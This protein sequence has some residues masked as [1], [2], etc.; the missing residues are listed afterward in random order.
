MTT[1]II[2]FGLDFHG[3]CS[4]V[5]VNDFVNCDAVGCGSHGPD[6]GP[7]HPSYFERPTAPTTLTVASASSVAVESGSNPPSPN[8]ETAV[9]RGHGDPSPKISENPKTSRGPVSSPNYRSS[10]CH[11]P[12]CSIPPI[13]IPIFLTISTLYL[14]N[15]AL[16]HLASKSSCL[17]R[18][19]P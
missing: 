13:S 3:F 14:L 2:F 10:T 11:C 12:N 1:T 16:A 6:G 19:S 7:D 4:D 15:S 9:G 8:L 17:H 5:C 18:R